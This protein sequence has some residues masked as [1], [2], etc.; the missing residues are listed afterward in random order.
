MDRAEK[1]QKV[2]MDETKPL[3]IRKVIDGHVRLI[4]VCQDCGYSEDCHGSD[5]NSQWR[6]LFLH[7]D[8][9]LD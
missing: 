2:A 3:Y 5:K 1:C 4:R 9:A 6:H 8:Y 7:P